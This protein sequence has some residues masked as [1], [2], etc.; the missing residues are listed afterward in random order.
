[1][2][3]LLKAFKV[4]Y[5]TKNF[6]QAAEILFISQPAVSNHIKQLET[7]LGIVLFIRNG[8]KE[9]VTTK[10]ADILYQ[11][12]LNLADDWHD[13]QSALEIQT[14]PK[15]QCKLVASHT[16]AVYYLPELLAQL[17]DHFSELTFVV[18]MHNSEQVLHEIEKH[19]AHFGFIEKPLVTKEIIRTKIL[20]D[21]L[22]R[23]GNFSK[24]LWLVRETDSGVYHYTE[25]YFLEQNIYPEKI[26]IKSNEI[27]LKCL[28][29]GIGQSI[30]SKKALSAAIPW[31][32]LSSSY[33]RN[34]Y[35]IKREHIKSPQLKKVEAF[36]NQFYQVEK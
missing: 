29:Q 36:I 17:I 6:S 5:E 28:E 22:V 16:F 21:E 31:E 26:T 8:R 25:Q 10:Q 14:T 34:F 23:A 2:F 32:K 15:E 18:E 35:F 30:V 24:E 27:I 3:K 12:L 7:E 11:H 9:I 33:Q 4:V 20:S 1:M 13:L 19:E